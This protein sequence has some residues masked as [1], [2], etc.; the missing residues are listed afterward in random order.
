VEEGS[1]EVRFSCTRSSLRLALAFELNLWTWLTREVSLGV[2]PPF[3]VI[4]FV[5]IKSFTAS[6]STRF[7]GV[8]KGFRLI[9]SPLLSDLIWAQLHTANLFDIFVTTVSVRRF[10]GED[11]IFFSKKSTRGLNCACPS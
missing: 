11:L 9:C 7:D 3:E 2:P 10:G 6:V 8:V 5:E 1:V 4:F